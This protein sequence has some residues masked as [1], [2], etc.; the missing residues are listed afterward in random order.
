MRLV[1]IL[2]DDDSVRTRIRNLYAELSAALT[3]VDGRHEWSVKVYVP[4][5]APSEPV[6]S[7]RPSS[8][9]AYLQRKR[10]QATRRRSSS[11]Q[12]L[13]SA[14]EIHQTL[15]GYVAAT[16]VLPPQDPQLT[17]RTDTMIL[18]GAY[19]V[20]DQD[21]DGFQALVTRLDDVYPRLEFEVKG[22][23]PPYSFATL[24]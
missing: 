9:A 12:H 24:D 5:E 16:R 8:G 21:A 4:R 19:L 6:G 13:Q 3:R 10:E 15:S 2:D 23:W 17:G 14:D 7:S 22:P 11:E 1:T 18:N 20:P